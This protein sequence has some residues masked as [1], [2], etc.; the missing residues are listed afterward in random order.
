MPAFGTLTTSDSTVPGPGLSPI[1]GVM[2]PPSEQRAIAGGPQSVPQCPYCVLPVGTGQ[3][4]VGQGGFHVHAECQG[5]RERTGVYLTT[6]GGMVV[7]SGW[8]SP[9]EAARVIE[10][11]NAAKIK[12]RK[13]AR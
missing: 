12:G 3:V 5:Q 1:F 4:V 13:V 7:G 10:M 6:C 8:L 2:H 9:Q 11:A